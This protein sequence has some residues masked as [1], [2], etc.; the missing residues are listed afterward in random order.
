[1]LVSPGLTRRG[2]LL[3]GWLCACVLGWL[4]VCLRA[5]LVGCVLACLV[6]WV[7]RAWAWCVAMVAGAARLAGVAWRRWPGRGRLGTS[8]D[9]WGR[10][11]VSGRRGRLVG[12]RTWAVA[13]SRGGPGWTGGEGEPVPGGARP[14]SSGRPG[15]PP[16][17]SR[18]GDSPGRIRTFP[19]V[20][21]VIPG[22]DV[23]A[24]VCDIAHV[25]TDTA[26]AAEPSAQ[27]REM[28]P[29]TV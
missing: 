29:E 4:V 12:G 5:W 26:S 25:E 2:F 24:R 23:W 19:D 14:W 20:N 1:M 18:P 22:V 10:L 6:V 8:G 16:A 9:V 3:L 11:A 21:T 15:T 13:P 27:C 7:G 28:R 17:T